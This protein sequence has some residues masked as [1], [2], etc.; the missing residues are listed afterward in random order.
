MR[1]LTK[2][3][4]FHPK[5]GVK[6][7][8]KSDR[9]CHQRTSKEGTVTVYTKNHYRAIIYDNVNNQKHLIKIW[10]PLL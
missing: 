2:R 6:K 7:S 9:N 5:K 4:I 1:N 10:T 8:D 3:E